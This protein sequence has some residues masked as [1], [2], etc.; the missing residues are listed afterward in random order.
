MVI[1]PLVFAFDLPIWR[2]SENL[3]APDAPH[4]LLL[5]LRN[6]QEVAWAACHLD[7][8]QTLWQH[9]PA[10]TNWWTSMVGCYNGTL[11]LHR[12]ASTE[13]PAPNG[14]LA[15]EAHNGNLR[16]EHSE[17]VFVQ[18][19]GQLL[20]TVRRNAA[21]NATY[22]WWQLWDGKKE[23]NTPEN[24][25]HTNPNHTLSTS[26]VYAP[27]NQYHD[28]LSKFIQK[29]TGQQALQTINYAEI[30]SCIAFLYYFYPQN[31]ITLS[32]S[33]LVINTAKEVLWHEISSNIGN[34]TE[35]DG[36]MYD[37]GQI[38]YLRSEYEL[39]VLKLSKQ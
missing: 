34:S 32:R 38:L 2:I 11:L 21:Q 39:T 22:E 33:L 31:S 7:T 17:G 16:W 10:Q 12:Y 19:N 30:G 6:Q 13:Q 26:L 5:E 25:P 14:I 24:Q 20:Q 37:H 36:F 28:F 1:Q 27:D 3:L 18:T 8:G 35:F 23:A 4:L 15:L 9:T 29:T